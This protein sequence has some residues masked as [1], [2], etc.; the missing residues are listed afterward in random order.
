MKI[1][2]AVLRHAAFWAV[3]LGINTFLYGYQRDMYRLQFNLF[4]HYM[5]MAMAATYVV[6][7]VLIPRFLLR[8]KILLFALLSAA[9][10]Y[11]C[12]QIQQ[13][14]VYYYVVPRYLPEYVESV[15]LMSIGVIFRIVTFLPYVAIAAAIKIARHWYRTEYLK[16]QVESENLKSELAYL[17]AQIQPHFLFNTLNNLYALVMKQ[18]PAAPGMVLRLSD[19]LDY[20]LH[21]CNTP[22]ISLEK[23]IALLENYIGLEKMRYGPRLDLSFEVTGREAGGT[24]APLLFLPLVENAFK[25]GTSRETSSPWMKISLVIGPDSISFRVEN[26][27]PRGGPESAAEG[28]PEGPGGAGATGK[29]GIGLRNLR[30]RLELLYPGDYSLVTEDRGKSFYA[31]LDIRAR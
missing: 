28:S 1:S 13:L 19:L 18:D 11:L 5:P 25:H 23:E 3:F 29:P 30:R 9:V 12:G 4:L 2:G 7:Y 16:Q 21:E 24:I 22:R 10:L 31:A 26:G 8:K 27:K 6:N 14:F 15:S 17:K 20:V